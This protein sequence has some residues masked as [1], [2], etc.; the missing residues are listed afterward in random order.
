MTGNGFID[1]EEFLEVMKPN[2]L[3]IDMEKE[4]LIA[5]FETLDRD[6]DG[7]IT[8]AELRFAL[9]MKGSPFTE[10]ELADIIKEADTD[11]NG[12]IDYRGELPS[13]TLIKI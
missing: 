10:E 3:V 5:S 12:K 6:H 9:K 13:I 8:I 4:R 1:Y 7:S 2:Y 11:G